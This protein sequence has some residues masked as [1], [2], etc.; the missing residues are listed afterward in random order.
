[1]RKLVSAFLLTSVVIGHSPV[2]VLPPL[3]INSPQAV[4]EL[5]K[6]ELLGLISKNRQL[7]AAELAQID[8][9]CP[10]FTC[11]YQGLG[12]TGWPECAQGTRAYLTLDDALKRECASGQQNFIFLKQAWW[13]S[14]APKPDAANGQ[15]PLASITRSKPGWYTFNYAVYFPETKTYA[16]MNHREFG[17]PLNLLRP[18]RAYLSLTPPPLSADRPAQLY[19]SSCR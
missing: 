14:G 9:G 18:Q 19:C 15:V 17:F 3:A 1:M 4:Q 13:E 10:G 8:R 5:T 2:N 11:L 16:W 12:V 7:D 6:T